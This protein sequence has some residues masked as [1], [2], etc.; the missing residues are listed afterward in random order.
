MST[1]LASNANFSPVA[2]V[3]TKPNMSFN[4]KTDS[5]Q[6]ARRHRLLKEFKPAFPDDKVLDP[7]TITR[8]KVCWEE[9]NLFI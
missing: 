8:L 4:F 9:D 6:R 3:V 1:R 7:F 2:E 5:L